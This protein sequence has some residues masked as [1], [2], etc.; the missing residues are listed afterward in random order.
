MKRE[1]VFGSIT[2][3]LLVTAAAISGY[4]RHRAEQAGGEEISLPEEGTAVALRSS[5]L[6]LMLSVVAY[7]IDPRWMRWSS[8]DLPGPL[9]WS[10][11]GLGTVSQVLALWILRTLGKHITSTVETR[12]EHELVTGGPYRWVRHPLYTVGTSF[13]VSLSLLAAN[14]FMGL[15]SL[16][17]LVM[18]LIRLPKE[19][20]KLIERFGDEYSAYVKRTGRLLPRL[21]V[22]PSGGRHLLVFFILFQDRHRGG[23]ED[24]DLT[25]LGEVYDLYVPGYGYLIPD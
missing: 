17:V 13:F 1:S 11:A 3:A 25:S 5:G 24:Q 2:A 4:H 19:E 10:G 22:W 15:A 9:R 12:E 23:F 21:Q 8:L 14:W 20:E 6:V 7:L 16:M 18:L